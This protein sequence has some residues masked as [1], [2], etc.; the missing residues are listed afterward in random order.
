[1]YAMVE[2]EI[3]VLC[4]CVL[5]HYEF[6][7]FILWI[8]NFH[9]VFFF[10][11]FVLRIH[12]L[13]LKSFPYSFYLQTRCMQWNFELRLLLKPPPFNVRPK[14]TCT[15]T[16]QPTHYLLKKLNLREEKITNTKWLICIAF[17]KYNV[18]RIGV[19]RFYA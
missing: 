1:M 16:H 18:H 14:N 10:G 8:F 4:V 13:H 7:S 3:D 19:F 15:H 12:K 9:R 5:L 2:V 17:F 6:T 11:W